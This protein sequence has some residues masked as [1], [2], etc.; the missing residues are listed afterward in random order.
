MAIHNPSSAANQDEPEYQNISEAYSEIMGI[1]EVCDSDSFLNF[2]GDSLGFILVSMAVEKYI[3]FL[4]PNWEALTIKE[5]ELIKTNQF[6]S[7]PG[8]I[9][10]KKSWVAIGLII[11]FFILGEVLLQTRNYYKTGRSAYTLLTAGSGLMFNE[12]LGTSTYRP[13]LTFSPYEDVVYSINSLGLR[14]PEIPIQKEANEL[15][16]AVAGAST[17][18]GIFAET[19]DRTLSA[20]LEKKLRNEIAK[21]Y[22]VNVINGGIEGNTMAGI[23]EVTE[24]I[25]VKMQPDIIIIYPGLND[26][27][28][29]CGEIEKEAVEYKGFDYYP[30]IPGWVLSK[31]LIKKNTLFIR[32]SKAKNVEMF[33]PQ[34]LD[35]TAYRQ[36][37]DNLV[38]N[39]K[40][41]GI[42]PVL[43]TVARAYNNSDATLEEKIDIA[44]S[45]LYYS[46]CLD[47]NSLIETGEKYNSEMELVAAKYQV[48]ILDLAKH[49]PGGEDYFADGGHFNFEGE[50]QAAT[51]IL[52]QLK[53]LELVN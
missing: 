41:Q 28:M 1:E 5:L 35:T 32:E 9:P 49:M 39:I 47:I 14:S 29:I 33:D 46:P 2:G 20:I 50:K 44:V 45:A 16:I 36:T 8:S 25:L 4:P 30:K 52:E 7:D 11:F 24:N 51:I 3:D 37:L 18:A 38:N 19:N 53:S 43:A 34:D 27:S 40:K 26:L 42:K 31:E 23:Q 22:N 17:I 13:N 48:P 10:L 6:K 21:N 12:D 15:R